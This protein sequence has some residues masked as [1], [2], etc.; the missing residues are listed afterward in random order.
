MPVLTS[1]STRSRCPA[2]SIGTGTASRVRASSSSTPISSTP[3]LTVIAQTS[4]ATSGPAV[5]REVLRDEHAD[6]IR[7]SVKAV[8]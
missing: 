2:S 6:V 7:E 8:A 4:T 3:P 5:S 1:C